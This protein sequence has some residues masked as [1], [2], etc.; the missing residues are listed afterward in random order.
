MPSG[1]PKP[2]RDMT[3]GQWE[4]IGRGIVK[5]ALDIQITDRAATLAYYGFL[6]LF[7]ALMIGVALLALFGEYPATYNSIIETL[8]E[9]APGKA[10]NTIDTALEDV[11]RNSGSAG[12]LLGIS[13]AVTLFTASNAMAAAIRA[14][15]EVDPN[16]SSRNVGRTLVARLGLTL[17]VMSL[18]FV[19][20]AALLVAGPIFT[21]I[22][23]A[24]GL[25]DSAQ[26]LVSVSRWPI[27]LAAL[28]GALV[29]LY[30]LGPGGERRHPREH[31]PGALL[32]TALGLAASWGFSFYVANFSS[33][34]ATYGFLGAVI[35]LLTWLYIL[36]VALIA[37]AIAN[38]E[39]R[40]ARRDG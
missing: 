2:L 33:Y 17:A 24:A 37:G 5:R 8:R 11:L 32:A 30:W 15:E 19:A 40:A 31:V 3:R 29:L 25:R 18:F 23:D 6:S 10:I 39:L 14:L 4:S 38:V 35:V 26:T 9:A 13:L 1:K 27:G 20:F 36:G 34:N 28:L 22:A 16:A 7:P 12:S 21:S